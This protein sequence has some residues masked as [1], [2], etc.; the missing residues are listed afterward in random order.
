MMMNE[1]FARYLEAGIFGSIIVLLILVLRLCLRRAPRRI[2]CLLWLLAAVRLLLPFQLESRLSLQP[3]LDNVAA[4]MGQEQDV[5]ATNV[6]LPDEIV[7]VPENE[8][9]Y[10]PQTQSVADAEKQH[11]SPID[12]MDLLSIIWVSVACSAVIYMIVSYMILKFRVREAVRCEDGI[13]ECDRIRGAFLLGYLRPKIYLPFRVSSTDRKFIIAHERAHIARGD[14]W[15]K[16][17]GFLCASIHWYNP[18]VWLSYGLLCRD[19]ELA[20]DERVIRGL[21]T[22]ERKGYSMALLNCGKRLSGASIC[23]VAFGEVSLKTRIKSILRYRKPGLWITVIAFVL[24]AATAVC[25]LTSPVVEALPLET[26]EK[27]TEPLQ[28]EQTTEASEPETESPTVQQTE[29]TEPETQSETAPTASEPTQPTVPEQEFNQPTTTP[30]QPQESNQADNNVQDTTT[31]SDEGVIASGAWD[32]GPITWE[33]SKDGVLSFNLNGGVHFQGA[34]D[35]YEYPWRKYADV[36]TQIVMEDGFHCI[37]QYVFAGMQNVTDIYLSSSI[38]EIG[39]GALQG[40]SSLSQITIPVPVEFIGNYAFAGCS[41]LSE[42]AIA[43]GSRLVEIGKSA[44]SAS[45]ISQFIAPSGLQTIGEKAFSSCSSLQKVVLNSGLIC[46]EG[47]AFSYCNFEN[48]VIPA[49][50][51]EIWSEIFANG[52]LNKIVFEGSKPN[53]SFTNTF[54][55]VTATAYYP[56]DDDTWDEHNRYL[57]GTLTWIPV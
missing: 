43:P 54:K 46:I 40:C 22:D 48:I 56:A 38:T 30:T 28:T 53:I 49:T 41:S 15:W 42:V 6:G 37:P 8:S 34:A 1:I 14:N 9:I 18:L 47:E 32:H 26:P 16:L 57:G 20:C 45:G 25:F 2:L 3:D 7:F 52:A 35:P 17:L 27:E 55:G 4:V 31:S 23:P 13:M 33:I 19:I 21:D 44:F 24:I 5:P 29:P 10:Q 39:D 12:T 11:K 50:V 51:D 36:I